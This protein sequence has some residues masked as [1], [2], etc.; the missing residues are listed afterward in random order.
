MR[1]SVLS[2]G[3]GVLLLLGGCAPATP[4]PTAAPA[5]P[6]ESKPAESK[7]AEAAKPAAPAASP[8]AAPAA[9]PA[10]PAASPAASPAAAAKPGAGIPAGKTFNVGIFQFV[11]HPA[12]D[13][14]KNGAVK[15]L[16]DAGFREGQNIRFDFQN[17]QRDMP[18]ITSI[19]QRYRDQNVDLVIAIGTQP[20]QGAVAVTKDNPRI[21]VVFNTVTDPYAAAKDVIKTATDKPANVTG[22]QALPPVKEAMQLVQ[23]VVPN[24]K[25][26]GIVW[27]PAEANSEVATRIAREVSKELNIE[28]VEQTVNSADEVLQAAQSL[29]TKNIDVFFVSTDS[30]VVSALESLVK[31]ANE[32]RKPLFGNDPASASRGAVAALGIDY[33]DQGYESGQMAARI[34]KGEAT[35]KDIAIEKSKKGYLAVNTRAAELQG[36]KL[37][38]DLLRQAKETHIE[39]APP[40]KP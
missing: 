8:A 4:S 6:A 33:E 24:A 18:T 26:F 9:S 16:A 11:Q 15:A 20:L 17:A 27:T 14:A 12:L 34:L 1:R 35:A 21:P 40:R 39:I 3:L 37:T 38:D 36:V 28:L 23:K 22:L 25:R 32:S 31:V 10:A 7:P 30:T 2:L 29:L 5:K 13:A 19:A